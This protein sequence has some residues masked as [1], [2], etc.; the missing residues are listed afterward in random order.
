MSQRM[1]KKK[2]SICNVKF[3]VILRNKK[4]P[5]HLWLIMKCLEKIETTDNRMLTVN[6][7]KLKFNEK[8]VFND[9][10]TK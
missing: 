1:I 9:N 4:S 8:V 3:D 6:D 5:L 10:V 2:N 7:F